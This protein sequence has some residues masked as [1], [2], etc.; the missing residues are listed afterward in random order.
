MKEASGK[1]KHHGPSIIAVKFY[2]ISFK[3][4][5]SHLVDAYKKSKTID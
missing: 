3:N 4:I 1:I 5:R 2:R